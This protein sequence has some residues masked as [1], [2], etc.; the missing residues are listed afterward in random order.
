MCI[1]DRPCTM[2]RVVGYYMCESNNK[3]F[4][5][6]SV[7]ADIIRLQH[8]VQNWMH[9]KGIDNFGVN[10]PVKKKI[11]IMLFQLLVI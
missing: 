8:T 3:N 10:V 2:R 5:S 7:S 6:S 1:R 4:N 11:L 9:F